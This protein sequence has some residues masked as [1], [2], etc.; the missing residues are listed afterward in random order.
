MTFRTEN[1]A[2]YLYV[3]L[4]ALVAG[5]VH[6]GIPVTV[7]VR[8]GSPGPQIRA[9]ALG[10]SY[11]TSALLPDENGRYYF[12]PTNKA[13]IRLLKTLGVRHL[14]IGGN[15]ADAPNIPVPKEQDIRTFFEFA[16]VA[17]VNVIYTLRLLD[18]DPEYAARVA[19]IIR[20]CHGG[21]LQYFAI[22]NEPDYYRD[23]D[24]YTNKW[25]AIR[26]AIIREFPDALFCGPDQN[27]SPELCQKLIRDFGNKS[28]RLVLI[29]QHSYPLGCAYKNPTQALQ[30]NDVSV[31]IPQNAA[32][33]RERMLSH[34]V[35]GIY[36][37]VHEKISR[38]L[39]GRELAYRLTEVNNYWFGGLKHASD[40]Y[41]A[42]LWAIDHLYWWLWHGARGVNFHT[43]DRCGGK[44]VIPCQYAAF[45]TAGNGYQVRPLSY[46]LKLFALGGQGRLVSADVIPADGKVVAYATAAD[47]K[48]VTVTIINRQHGKGTGNTKVQIK[49]DGV[50]GIVKAEVIFLTAARGN[51]AAKSNLRLGGAEIRSDGSW[52]GRWTRVRSLDRA[53]GMITI[54][55]PPASAAVVNAALADQ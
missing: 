13:L 9:D 48:N 8:A 3:A 24:V 29:T 49:L 15:S 37:E 46:A 21:T 1:V 44:I 47:G 27:P 30:S 5:V 53:R 23:Y 18:G 20:D 4:C 34:E 39:K 25:T 26:D 45:V 12:H 10:L 43:G 6:A 33:A 2:V 52:D 28:G 19:G 50:P 42:A 40:T 55:M 31:L 54:V 16:K 11:E 17:G 32:T 14:R 35:W 51:I 38:G 36:D 22:G 41:A 7:L